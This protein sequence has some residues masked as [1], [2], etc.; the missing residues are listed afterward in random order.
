[1]IAAKSML[2]IS[3]DQ[4]TSTP[5]VRDS[6]SCG[7]APHRA[8]VGRS[9]IRQGVLSVAPDGP[10]RLSSGSRGRLEPDAPVLRPIRARESETGKLTLLLPAALS[11]FTSFRAHLHRGLAFVGGKM[12]PQRIRFARDRRRLAAELFLCRVPFLV[13]NG[14]G[15]R[16]MTRIG[17][18]LRPLQ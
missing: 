8:V 7:L 12:K 1:M 17:D 11:L 15:T 9:F 14:I 4:S 5:F 16:D 2:K 18:E 13:N 6:R 3:W 10:C